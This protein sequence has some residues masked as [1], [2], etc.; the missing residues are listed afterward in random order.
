[1]G[2]M[3]GEEGYIYPKE[4]TRTHAVE[5]TCNWRRYRANVRKNRESLHEMGSQDTERV[6]HCTGKLGV[7]AGERRAPQVQL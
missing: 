2:W 7:V 4:N 1:M 5:D 6:I 3:Q